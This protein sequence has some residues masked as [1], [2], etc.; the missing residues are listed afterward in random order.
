MARTYNVG[1]LSVEMVADTVQYVQK[2]K[3]A[4]ASTA[5]NLKSIRDEQKKTASQST[6]T[7]KEVN[8]LNSVMKKLGDVSSIVTGPL[9]GVASRITALNSLVGGSGGI[10]AGVG[11]LVGGL[12]VVTAAGLNA[13]MAYAQQYKELKVY[14]D[15]AGVTVRELRLLTSATNSV[16]ISTE[17]FGDQVKDVQDRIGDFIATGGGPFADVMEVLGSETGITAQKLQE[18]SG[19]DALEAIAHAMEQANV[20]MEQQIFLMESLASDSAKLLPLYANNS[21]E[22]NRLEHQFNI[23]TRTID[24]HIQTYSEL[25]KQLEIMSDNITDMVADGL[26]PLASML[27]KVAE[28]TNFYFA[29][30]EEGTEANRLNK[31]VELREEIDD[32]KT[33]LDNTSTASGRFMNALTL[34]SDTADS[35]RIRLKQL[36]EQ[37]DALRKQGANALAPDSNGEGGKPK[38]L[39]NDLFES[40]QIELIRIYYAEQKRLEKEAEKSRLKATTEQ[41]K[42][43]K[44]AK[45]EKL[46]AIKD[47]NKA[48]QENADYM[49][50]LRNQQLK[51]EQDMFELSK[52]AVGDIG[53]T[54]AERYNNQ[55]KL[56]QIEMDRELEILRQNYAN[57]EGLEE[58]YQEAVLG[59][60][61]KYQTKRKDLDKKEQDEIDKRNEERIKKMNKSEQAEADTMAGLRQQALQKQNDAYELSRISLSG[62]QTGSDEE[63]QARQQELLQLNL[64]RELELLRQNYAGKLELET[65]YQAAVKA[66][67]EQYYA[68]TLAAHQASV[69]AEMQLYQQMGNAIG[70]QLGELAGATDEEKKELT[71]KFLMNQ[72]IAA[73]NATLNYFAAISAHE[74]AAAA[75]GPA[76]A[77]YLATQ[78]A[79]ATAN[80]QKNL[81]GIAAVS[82]VG[83]VAGQFHSGTDSVPSEGSYLL[84]KGE[85]VIAPKANQDLSNFMKQNNSGM[86]KTSIDASIHVSGNVTDQKWFSEQLVKQRNVIAASVDKVNRERPNTRRK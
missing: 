10:A 23:T 46:K 50:A 68:D 67:K 11:L 38:V 57:R 77:P 75:L 19:P 84:Q 25:S 59:I 22:L 33:A 47:I 81:M 70:T 8:G 28:A 63:Q 82:L 1:R 31:M 55:R 49:E 58:K 7:A 53:D 69:N 35:L 37:Y 5:K 9:G 76:G 61:M 30:L 54:E 43:D 3:E 86:G 66:T 14:A 34:Q 83:G 85:R 17:K 40:P 48:E 60:E 6:K 72:A 41:E 2:I 16:G 64:D 26:E 74:A 29:S 12:T 52:K 20:P 39:N 65:Q 27:V 78:T 79:L 13:S 56:L 4:E 73:A 36:E 21:Q 24:E 42:A 51:Q 44:K 71:K 80:W 62:P 15:I 18:M 32:M 45:K